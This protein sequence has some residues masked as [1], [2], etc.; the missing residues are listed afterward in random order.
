MIRKPTHQKVVNYSVIALLRTRSVHPP[1]IA[2][3]DMLDNVLSNMVSSSFNMIEIYTFWNF[4]EKTE[5]EY[6]FSGQANLTRFV[7]LSRNQIL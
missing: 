1:R 2:T 3:G 6:D 7:F 5:G 4:H